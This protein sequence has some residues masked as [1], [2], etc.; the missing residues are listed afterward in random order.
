MEGW[1]EA[2]V[3]FTKADDRF[4]LRWRDYLDEPEISRARKDLGL[5]LP[6][7]REGLG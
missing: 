6:G 4:V 5:M 1:Y 3:L 7:S 2:V